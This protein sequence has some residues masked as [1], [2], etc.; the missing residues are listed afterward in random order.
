MGTQSTGKVSIQPVSGIKAS[1]VM[2]IRVQRGL[3]L[4]QVLASGRVSERGQRRLW[5][6]AWG[7][8]LEA[9][10]AATTLG[11]TQ[12]CWVFSAQFSS[13]QLLLSFIVSDSCNP[14]DPTRLLC[15]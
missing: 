2:R 10:V 9:D 8:C 12:G 7:W 1:R 11:W 6:S 15:P 5:D 4:S 3:G 14:M 13:I